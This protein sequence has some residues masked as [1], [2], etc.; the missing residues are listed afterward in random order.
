MARRL[1]GTYLHC[2]RHFPTIEALLL[3]L[4]PQSLREKQRLHNEFSVARVN[5]RM[6]QNDARPDIW[7]LVMEKEGGSGLTKGEMYANANIFMIGGTETTATLLSGL[8]YH[9][10][11]NPSKLEQLTNEIR[12]AFVSEDLITIERLQRLNYLH[13]CI[14]EGLRMYPP[15]S[16]GLPRIVP[17]PG[18]EIGGVDVPAQVISRLKT[19]RIVRVSQ[20]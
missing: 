17:P 19:E 2:V 15:I 16:N 1:P 3:K 12:G 4:I 10:L 5:K 9:L 8:T 6:Q 18:A 14:E 7:G 11:R 20:S 13:A